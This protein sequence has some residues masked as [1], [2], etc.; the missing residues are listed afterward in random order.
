M[1]R[2]QHKESTK[3]RNGKYVSN[4]S[5]NKCFKTNHNQV[6]IS[7]LPKIKL[8]IRVIKIEVLRA[9]MIQVRISTKT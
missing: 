1:R 3:A 8:E 5:A 7:E 9:N 2:N 6:E 4:K